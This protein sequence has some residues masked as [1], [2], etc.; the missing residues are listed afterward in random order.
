VIAPA[1]AVED[2][3]MERVPETVVVGECWKVEENIGVS[4]L[5]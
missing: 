3:A 1:D 4:L 2:E 5:N